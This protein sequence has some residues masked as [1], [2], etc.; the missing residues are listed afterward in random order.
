MDAIKSPLLIPEPPLQV[1]PSLAAEVGLNEAIVIQQVHYWLLKSGK[2]KDGRTWIYNTY[3]DWKKQFPFWSTRTIM[4]IVAS[5]KKKKILLTTSRF[6]RSKF[7]TT[8][9]YSIR[10]DKL[11]TL[12]CQLVT[13]ESDN[14]S[15]SEHDK[16]STLPESTETNG[17][18]EP[19]I[20]PA[21]GGVSVDE[22]FEEFW[23]GRIR[24][25]NDSKA[26]ALKA[27]RSSVKRGNTPE[28]IIEGQKRER[29]YHEARQTAP[30]FIPMRSTWLN[31]DRHLNDYDAAAEIEDADD[32]EFRR[33]MA[34]RGLAHMLEPSE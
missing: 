19:P 33:M 2:Q 7:E 15:T 34:E 22:R 17:K 5:L 9:W 8:L 14:L 21:T 10:Y 32:R 1:L 3:D 12:G 25:S 16:L 23:E 28:A 24:R 11:S 30:Q 29:A 31:Q 18:K 20:P 4:R 6:N 27:F 13:T 26:A